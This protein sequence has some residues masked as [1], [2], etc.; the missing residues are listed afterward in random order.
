MIVMITTLEGA[1][2]ASAS[3]FTQYPLFASLTLVLLS[4]VYGTLLTAD[5]FN[6]FVFI[7]VML[8]PSYGLYATTIYRR[9]G[10]QQLA[11]LRLFI[12]ANLFASYMLLAGVSLVLGSFGAVIF[13]LL[14]GTAQ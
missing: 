9:G 6:F 4:F 12:V 13:A 11:G 8:L 7:E 14:Q 2:L 3:R 5:I 10:R 1:C